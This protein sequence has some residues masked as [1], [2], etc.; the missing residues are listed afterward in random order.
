MPRQPKGLKYT[1]EYEPDMSRMVS[2]LRVL[3]DYKNKKTGGDNKAT[4]ELP[5]ITVSKG[6]RKLSKNSLDEL[7]GAQTL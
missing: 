7:V 1:A 6:S 4:K 5:E 2:A 3:M